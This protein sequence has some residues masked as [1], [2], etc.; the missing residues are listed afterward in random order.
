MY[1]VEHLVNGYGNVQ[2]V[3][4]ILNNVEIL[5]IPFVNPDGYVV[6]DILCSNYLLLRSTSV[7]SLVLS[8]QGRPGW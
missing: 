7:N 1:I 6:S 5:V 2:N 4:D 3:T 8:L